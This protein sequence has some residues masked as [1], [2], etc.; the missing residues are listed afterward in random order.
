M[1][2]LHH[3]EKSRSHRIV[4]LLELLGVEYQIKTYQRDAKTLLAPAELK[5][6]HPL[7]KSPVLTDGDRVIAESGALIDYLVEVYG[8][9]RLQP[10]KDNLDAWVD[11]RYWLHYAEGSLMPWL[12][13]N[14]VFTQIPKQPMP[15]FIKPVAKGISGKVLEQLVTPN[16]NTH[17]PF[18]EQQLEGKRWLLGEQLTAAD[19]QMSFPLQAV[20]ARM[21]VKAYPNLA[22]YVARIQEE[23]SWQQ[24]IAK[25]GPLK[26]P[27]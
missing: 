26:F 8:Q 21:D 20:A 9:G 13:M 14:L 4:W 19:V 10:G 15:F 22:A 5:A 27:G 11:Y 7:G 6:I 16:L 2:T 1:L 18:I 25:V 23:P 24:V 3:L 12:L 17:L